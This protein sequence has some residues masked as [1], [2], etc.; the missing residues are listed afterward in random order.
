MRQNVAALVDLRARQERLMA[1]ALQLQ[2]DMLDFCAATREQVAGLLERTP[3]DLRTPRSRAATGNVAQPGAVLGSGNLPQPRT[4]NL[5][6]D[7]ESTE[8]QRLPP[9]LQPRVVSPHGTGMTSSTAMCRSLSDF[10]NTLTE[11]ECTNSTMTASETTVVKATHNAADLSGTV[12][13]TEVG[14]VEP[15][16]KPGVEP[17]GRPCCVTGDKKSL[18][19][20]STPVTGSTNDAAAVTGSVTAEGNVRNRSLLQAIDDVSTAIKYLSTSTSTRCRFG[21]VCNVV[22]RINE[23]NRRWARLVL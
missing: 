18:D 13:A 8:A 9:P 10:L 4:V 12:G 14:G 11:T 22:G 1:E 21:L 16:G 2:Q 20:P 3:L 6:D 7:P 17:G 5:D 15:A 23:V 19:S